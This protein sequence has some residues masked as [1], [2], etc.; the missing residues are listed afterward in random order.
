MN[1]IVLLSYSQH[2][3]L[4]IDFEAVGDGGGV[5]VPR[6]LEDR[7]GRDSGAVRSSGSVT[8]PGDSCG[9]GDGGGSGGGGEGSGGGGGGCGGGS[10]GGGSGL[11]EPKIVLAQ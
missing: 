3:G 11:A 2:A 5:G 7:A 1:R 10:G 4:E 8:A 9:G 6:V